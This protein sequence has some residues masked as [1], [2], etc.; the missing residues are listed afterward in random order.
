MRR[1]LH[2]TF[3]K[4][5]TGSQHADDDGSV[6]EGHILF[7]LAIHLHTLMPRSGREK[8]SALRHA[9]CNVIHELQRRICRDIQGRD[10][11]VRPYGPGEELRE[12]RQAQSWE[13]DA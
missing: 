8:E 2:P 10:S 7:V 12:R 5:G 9:S 13:V 3:L 6:I 1:R 4:T 11:H